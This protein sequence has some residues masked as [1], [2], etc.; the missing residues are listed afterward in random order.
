[1]VLFLQVRRLSDENNASLR[2]GRLSIFLK[3]KILTHRPEKERLKTKNG[4]AFN[5]PILILF[6]NYLLD[7]V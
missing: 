1:M 2:L 3:S 7:S 5:Y 6:T 4:I